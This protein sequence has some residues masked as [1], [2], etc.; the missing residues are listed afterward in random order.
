MQVWS[1][2]SGSSGNCYLVREGATHVLVDAGLPLR[3]IEFELLQ[4][5]V[6]PARL[7]AILVTHEHTDH[8]SSAIALGRRLRVPVVC[9]AGTW[10]A[11]GG[12]SSTGCEHVTMAEGRCLTVGSLSVEGFRLPHDAREP[13]GF[14][15]RSRS[16]VMLLSSYMWSAT[17]EVVERAREADLVILESNHD[18]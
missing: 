13:L 14:S 9:S 1:L 2:S 15:L 7:S 3:R 16:A 5:N 8:W 18:V 10:E 12:L 17:E 11:G 6:S 4:L